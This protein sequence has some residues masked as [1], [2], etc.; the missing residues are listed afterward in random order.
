M[1]RKS[2]LHTRREFLRTT[3]LGAAATWTVPLF[4]ERTFLTL[5]A[6][7]A[8]SAVQIVSGRDSRILVVLQLAGGN[9]GLNTVVPYADD[10]YH[11][12]R[13]TLGIK[14]NSALKLGDYSGFHPN[15]SG[16]KEL[17]EEGHLAVLQGVGY[18]NPN[19][20]HF[21]S[22][23]IWQTA[24]DADRVEKFGWLGRYFD[25]CCA[26]ADPSAGVS[27][28]Q[29]VPQAFSAS[30]PKG[31]SFARPDQFRWVHN[32]EPQA[33]ESSAEFL[34]RQLNRPETVPEASASSG[35]TISS[36]SGSVAMPGNT[37]DFLQRTALD[38]Q[39]SS[40]KVLEIA[41]KYKSAVDYPQGRLA[42]SLSLVGRMIAGGM[43]A[44]VYYVS[45]GGYDT[46]AQQSGTHD[47]LMRELNDAVSAFFKDLKAQGNFDRVLLMT[48]SEFGRRVAQNGSGGTDHGAAAPLFLAGGGV[49]PGLHGE[50]PS[51]IDLDNGDLKF[52]TD[53][54]SVYATVLEKWL[55]APSKTILGKQFPILPYLRT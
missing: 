13:P 36:I 24:S 8:D 29:E 43:P 41:S 52:H 34:F 11:R 10:A 46:H 25:N 32:E 23:E 50:H 44:R 42:D 39:V 49:K 19:R 16:F 35:S 2:T 26:G 27:I 21:R 20:S 31:V 18:P 54:R 40:D 48:F 28:G 3:V 17:Y 53:F 4:L 7:A 9:D 1:R 38:A 14:G 15:L 12:A 55:Q 5:N 45:Q 51:L 6:G 37:L 33:G 47:R 30:V 22:T